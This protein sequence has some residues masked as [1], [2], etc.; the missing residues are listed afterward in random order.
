MSAKQI[1][2]PGKKGNAS[3]WSNQCALISNVQQDQA[4][5]TTSQQLG[6][7]KVNAAVN[8][9]TRAQVQR[10]RSIQLR[11]IDENEVEELLPKTLSVELPSPITGGEQAREQDDGSPNSIYMGSELAILKRKRGPTR[12]IAVS[13]KRKVGVKI[14]VDML[15]ESQRL[16]GEGAQSFISE[17]SC[18]IRNFGKWRAPKWAKLPEA[19]REKMFK[20]TTRKFVHDEGEYVKPA[21]IKQIHSQYRNHRYNFHKLF[22]KYGT[23]EHVKEADWIYLCD[24]FYSSQFKEAKEERVI[25][26]IELY[27]MTHFSRKKNGLIDELVAN[28]LTKMK[29]LSKYKDEGSNKTEDDVYVEVVG[30]K[31]GKKLQA[32]QHAVELEVQVK[33]QQEV[34]E[35]LENQQRETNNLLQALAIQLQMAKQGNG[36]ASTSTNW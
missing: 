27:D 20:M 34:M 29:D 11:L 19:D 31:R 32:E 15:E 7:R 12:N 36:D 17:A 2:G 18:V 21:L 35:K 1:D 28:N 33:A 6:V 23:K 13:R 14:K 8:A 5:N 4:D 3:A 16:I 25:G 24:Y 22:L 10:K 26:P 30:H 9:N